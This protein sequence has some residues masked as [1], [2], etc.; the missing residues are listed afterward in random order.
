MIEDF[1]RKGSFLNRDGKA[2]SNS[3]SHSNKK[4]CFVSTDK[5]FLM[6][7]LIKLSDLKDCYFV[8][9]TA[10]PK[11]GMYLGRCFFT[12]DQLV[13][14]YWA[15]YKL[16]PKLMCNIQDD[17]FSKSFRDKVMSYD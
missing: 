9:L 6:E 1:T 12:S 10:E 13:G 15:K 3:G 2:R 8:K 11:D 14:E 16:H 7:L 5:N 4:L 17:D